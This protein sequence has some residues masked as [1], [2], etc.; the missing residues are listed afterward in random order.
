MDF[1]ILKR[2][3][4]HTAPTDPIE[5]FKRT[6]N[7][8]EALNDLWA[9]QSE[10][11]TKWNAHRT[12]F[13]VLISLNTGAGKSI[14]GLLIAQSLVNERG[15]KVVYVCA[16]ND[17]IQQTEKEARKLGLKFSVRMEG[18]FSNDLY[19][20][21]RAFC[22]TNYS[23]MFNAF[24]PFRGN[25]HPTAIIFDDAHVAEKFVRDA[26]TVSISKRIHPDL[27]SKLIG[28]LAPAFEQVGRKITLEQTLQDANSAPIMVPNFASAAFASQISAELTIATKGR[29]ADIGLKSSFV[30]LKDLIQHCCILISE[31]TVELSPPFVPTAAFPILHEGATRRIYLSATLKSKA[32][33]VRTFGREPTRTIEP[34]NDA[35]NGERLILF[36]K[37]LPQNLTGPALAQIF[38]SQ[39]K[40]LIAVP[41]TR[42]AQVYKDVA[43]PPTRAEFSNKLD[44]FRAADH[45]AFVLVY[46]VDGIDLPHKTCRIMLIDGLPT[47][48]S[49]LER[50]QWAELSM[51]NLFNGR[52][53]NR[54][55]QLFGRINRGRSDYGVFL[56]VG[57]D[58]N[59][60]LDTDRFMSLL[61][62]LI[63]RQILL[64]RNAVESNVP[65]SFDEVV[66]VVNAVLR[67][68]D[69]WLTYYR[70]WIDGVEI[71]EG[72]RTRAA[73]LESGFVALAKAEVEFANKLWAGDFE[74]AKEFFIRVSESA[75]V[76]D[77]KVAGWHALWIGHCFDLAGQSEVARE[78]YEQAK[79]R[80]SPRLPIRRYNVNMHSNEALSRLMLKS[81]KRASLIENLRSLRGLGKM[82]VR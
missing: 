54:L 74:E 41:G 64:G 75:A 48:S 20:T 27:F 44:A 52:I 28:I 71:N 22:I 63:H 79:S 11:L 81:A 8:D 70:D 6:P 23:S 17:L 16:T 53:A 69:G 77:A 13:D 33:F 24:T 4:A 35:G 49:L 12:D 18:S 55:T 38:A 40:I 67:R 82:R 2:P 61:P 29:G 56:I 26:L 5:I 59:T 14:V 34:E 32:D 31:P 68:D 25:T 60:W 62:D 1:G 21:E 19:E 45:G 76:L 39:N 46:R 7:L 57:R 50:Y 66:S 51:Q 37:F 10:A 58:I 72:E 78:Y 43:T 15:P 9:G 3:S 30:A 42:G 80:L 36:H 73:T 47:G 65:K